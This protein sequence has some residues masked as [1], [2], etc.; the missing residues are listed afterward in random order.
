VNKLRTTGFVIDKKQKLKRQ[1]FTE[2]KLHDIGAK[3]ELTPSKSLKPL[4]Q[5]TGV[6]KSSARTAT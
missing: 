3:L 4:A 2:E 1:V 6:S 5:E